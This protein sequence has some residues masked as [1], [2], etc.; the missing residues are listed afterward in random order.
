MLALAAYACL[1]TFSRGV[2]A[3]VPLS[4]ATLAVLVARQRLSS[5]RGAL[6]LVFGKALAFAAVVAVCGFVV[7]RSGGYRAVLAA[8]VVVSAAIPADAALRRLDLASGIASIVAAAV[9][10]AGGA[11]VASV[12][13]KGP[14]VVFAIATLAT[15]AAV[16]HAERT[17]LRSSSAYVV[18]GWLLL[19]ACAANVA[20]FWGGTTAFHDSAVML[21]V[22]VVLAFAASRLPRSV[23]P[24][25][26]R[27]QFATV[28][29]AACVLAAV[30]V[31]AVGAYM[32][33]RFASSRED[34]GGR[35]HHWTQ[36]IGRLRGTTDWLLGKGLGRFP[37]TSLFESI[38]GTAPGGY[39]MGQRGGERFL[40]VAAP[41][42]A[43]I[44]FNEFFRVSQRVSVEPNATYTAYVVA[45]T[46][47]KTDLHIEL[48][49]KQLL[50]PADC[51]ATDLHV[52]IDHV[53]W[54][55][56]GFR[57]ATGAIGARHAFGVRPAFL[58]V[59]VGDPGATVEIRSVRLVGPDGVDVVADG[60]FVDGTTRWFSSSDRIHLPWH[61]KNIALAVLFD[62][63]A[64]GLGLFALLVGGALLRTA[65]GR[66]RRDPD[67][68]FVAAAIVGYGV[69]GA[70]DSLIDVPRVALL[71]EL[72]V[73]SALMLRPPRATA[74]T[75][76][77]RDEPASPP[78]A[79]PAPSPD[80][81]EAAARALR[82]QRAFGDRRRP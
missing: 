65:L 64:I 2:Y 50:Y 41:R 43:Y 40:V 53:G 3:A 58:A 30:A 46:D 57:I 13:P 76:T 12:L 36:G 7:F 34:L 27:D 31:F 61:I 33:G 71:F 8:F 19:A 23:W 18:A 60:R 1:V 14:Y 5:E 9:L 59:A 75:K 38:D 54:H 48:C 82:R 28:G 80:V 56:L 26:R 63:G 6:W 55:E 29:L 78:P 52:P 69:V 70:F 17:P 77:T 66:A 67:A 62:Q 79:A 37:A 20:R 4:I 72:V 24:Q 74:K 49:E 73:M 16:V 10:A 81:D 47:A 68:P 11:L 32:G 44:G 21:A 35:E 15:A 22:F 42:I 25:R 51:R 45:R 39:R